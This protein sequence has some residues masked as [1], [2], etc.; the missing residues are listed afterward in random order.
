MHVAKFSTHTQNCDN[1]HAIQFQL[2]ILWISYENYVK[3]FRYFKILNHILV[4]ALFMFFIYTISNFYYEFQLI[5]KLDPFNGF[6][7]QIQEWLIV[8]GNISVSYPGF[9]SK[10]LS[11][12][13]TPVLSATLQAVYLMSTYKKYGD[14]LVI[15][16][17]RLKRALWNKVMYHWKSE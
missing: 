17:T 9:F 3:R 7:L 12:S 14:C 6:A 8:A 10:L 1:L 5:A 13:Y 2:S 4:S 15:L 11:E 16:W